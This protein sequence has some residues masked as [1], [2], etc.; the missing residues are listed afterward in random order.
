M[1]FRLAIVLLSIAAWLVASDHCALAGVL[2]Q[3]AA[4]EICP[5]H[6]SEPEKTPADGGLPC[7]KTLCATPAQMKV[8]AGY[9]LD[10]FGL[11]P[12]FEIDFPLLWGNSTAPSAEL[13]TGPPEIRTFAESVL[14]RSLLAHAPPRLS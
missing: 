11:Q 10:F 14:Q 2:L 13:D 6:S 3:P 12:Y 5:G 4:Q 1:R 9:N 8:S 7:C